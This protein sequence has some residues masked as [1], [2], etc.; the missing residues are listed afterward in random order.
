MSGTKGCGPVISVGLVVHLVS[1]LLLSIAQTGGQLLLL[2]IV[3]AFGAGVAMM[4]VD[5][6]VCDCY[7]GRETAQTLALIGI[8]IMTVPLATPMLGVKLQKLGGWRV[9]FVPLLAYAVPLLGLMAGS[10]PKPIKMKK[11]GRDVFVVAAGRF[12]WVLQTR[13]IMG[14]LSF[15]MFSF[16]SMFVFPIEPSFICMRLHGIS[17]R[18]YA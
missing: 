9:I 10:L 2:R 14:C 4:V 1:V 8:I 7:E 12:K 11:I 3:Q 15:Q 5:A 13:A 17:P 16:S 18:L 6:L